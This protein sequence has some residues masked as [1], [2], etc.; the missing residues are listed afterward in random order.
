MTNTFV[1]DQ[2][3]GTEKSLA[4]LCQSSLVLMDGTFRCVPKIFKQLY[5][6]HGEING[7]VSTRNN[8]RI[9]Q[10]VNVN[11]TNTRNVLCRY[12]L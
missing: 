12:S 6:I 2:I 10:S 4:L 3:F 9:K 7:K 1:C 11:G 5:T 8:V